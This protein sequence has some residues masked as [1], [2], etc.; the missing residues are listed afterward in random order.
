MRA[1][2]NQTPISVVTLVLAA[3]VIILEQRSI[4]DRMTQ[5]IVRNLRASCLGWCYYL[6]KAVVK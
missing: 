1:T 6:A 4:T 3:E 2:K 5:G